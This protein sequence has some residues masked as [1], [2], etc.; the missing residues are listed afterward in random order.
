MR[1]IVPGLVY[2]LIWRFVDRSWFFTSDAERGRYRFFFARAMKEADWRPLANA[3]MSNHIHHALVAGSTPLE[4]W[5]KRAHSPFA[6]WMNQRHG[7]L[8]PLFADRCKA[9]SIAPARVG[10]LIA[11]IHNN[12]VRAGVVSRPGESDWTTHRAYLGLDPR[13]R[14]LCVDEGLRYAGCGDAEQFD[15]W[16]RSDAGASGEV[17]VRELRRQVRRL[18]AIELATPHSDRTPVVPL[19][20]RPFAHMRPDPRRL[21]DL[22][23]ATLDVSKHVFC[24][25]RR[26]PAALLGRE[27]VVHVGLAA[28]FTTSD[29]AAVLGLTPQAVSRIRQRRV[30]PE[31]RRAMTIV[32]E[33]LQLES[34]AERSF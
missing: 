6:Q 28:G 21:V 26:N 27:V 7:R 3:L 14:W 23:A 1:Q 30:D 2:H 32:R 13:P 11:Y 8:G 25:R 29:L 33:Q 17:D 22:V 24:S 4:A 20:T 34:S 16:V 31:H 9:F 15:T 18:G 19:V 12:P 10:H 5:T